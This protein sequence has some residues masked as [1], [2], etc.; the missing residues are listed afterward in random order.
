M[1]DQY[2][3]I[4]TPAMPRGEAVGRIRRSEI[5]VV[6][7]MGKGSKAFETF[8]MLYSQQ[9]LSAY[10]LPRNWSRL[11][12]VIAIVKNVTGQ[13]KRLKNCLRSSC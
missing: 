11:L 5:E 9:P 12:K 3:S 10:R 2:F 8:D 1:E 7:G 4:Y 6:Q 13:K